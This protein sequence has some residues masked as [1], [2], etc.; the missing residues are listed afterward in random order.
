MRMRIFVNATAGHAFRSYGHAF[1]L[2][3]LA[4]ESNVSR[5]CLPPPIPLWLFV[6]N[7]PALGPGQQIQVAFCSSALSACNGRIFKIIA[8]FIPNDGR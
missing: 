6:E 1:T 4:W 3:P 7:P 2:S 5:P 8:N